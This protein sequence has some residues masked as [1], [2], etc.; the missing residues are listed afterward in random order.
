MQSL[1]TPTVVKITKIAKT[2]VQIGSA[3]LM[4]LYLC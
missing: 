1:V 2:K 3:N 4:F